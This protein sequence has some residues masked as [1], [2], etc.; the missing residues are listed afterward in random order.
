VPADPA[1]WVTLSAALF[2][3]G[4]PKAAARAG[5]RA[6]TLLPAS[7]AA[8]NNLG[9]ALTSNGDHQ[10]ALRVLRSALAV[11]PSCGPALNNCGL[12]HLA[13]GREDRA[14][15]S[16][17]AALTR[18]PAQVDAY[19]N[20]SLGARRL[21]RPSLGVLAI[22][23][24]LVLSPADPDCLVSLG[25]LLVT[26]GEVDA[27]SAWIRRAL[28]TR[29]DHLAATASLSG[30][31][32][33]STTAT[34]AT[35]TAAY[36]TLASIAGRHRSPAAADFERAP[37]P[38]RPLTV[39]YVSSTF[40]AHPVGLQLERLLANHDHES[41]HVICYAD[42]PRGDDVTERLRALVPRWHDTTGWDDSEVADAVRGAG[43]DILVLVAA[44]EEGGRR[45]MGARRSAPVQISLHDVATT[46]LA[47]VDWWLADDDLTP[48][49]GEEWFSE[50]PLM[51]TKLFQYAAPPDG[52][53]V[54]R[55]RAMPG[56]QVF[57]SFN[58][59]SKLSE[60]CIAAWA[61]VLRRLP[62]A[63]LTL[64]YGNLYGDPMVA[65]RVRRLFSSHGVDG[66]RL[67]LLAGDFGRVEH[68]RCLGSMD[69]ALDP[70]P[71]NG[72][73]ATMEALF[74]GVPVITLAGPRFVSRMGRSILSSVGLPD[75]V[76]E[77]V[78][79][80]AE[81][82]VSLAR[83]SLRQMRLRSELRDRLLA[84]PLCDAV[85]HARSVEAAYRRSWRHWCMGVR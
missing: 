85:S 51:V 76:A 34:E 83:D 19:L 74:M 6:V 48:Y 61:A 17:R 81:R 33:Y 32:S 22:V 45:F 8:S 80:Y 72:N 1:H 14:I 73:T 9:A 68:L 75:L 13:S 21:G 26:I 52:P 46:G 12:A 29:S 35:R 55:R 50:R 65:E 23:N 69:I 60:P 4:L 59:P 15:V 10:I 37:I 30:A 38:D 56:P 16:F 66:R 53:A 67:R 25:N 64:K 63:S 27:G 62:D 78:E 47:E 39:G 36:T 2:R 54:I 41:F 3:L 70:F 77:S 11:D 44:H 42:V 18:D 71:F 20:L 49:P 5:R 28:A 82:A 40:R 43:V 31:I 7:A 79:S 58:N 57:A 24:A 84:S